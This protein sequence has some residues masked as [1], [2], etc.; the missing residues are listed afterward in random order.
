MR[1]SGLDPVAAG[2]LIDR[3]PG[4]PLAAHVRERLIEGTRGNPLAL[5]ELPS[6]LS[7]GQRSG[8]EP[9]PDPLPVG[10]D[11]ERAF[12]E[13][14]HRLPPRPRSCC[15][16]PPRTTRARPRVVVRAAGRLGARP[17]GAGRGRAGRA[18]TRTGR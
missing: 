1:L 3:L 7:D 9:L 16:S 12:L 2:E 10:A 5:L 15:S 6:T 8:A 14:V 13:R 18:R 17:R 4:R 11:V